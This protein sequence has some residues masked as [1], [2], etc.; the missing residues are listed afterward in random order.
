MS[1]SFHKSWRLPLAC[2]LIYGGL[3]VQSFAAGF[4]TA[5]TPDLAGVIFELTF[6]KL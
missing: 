1:L 3:I 2:N 4:I 5:F 6:F